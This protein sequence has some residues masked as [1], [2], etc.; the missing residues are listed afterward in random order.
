MNKS[1]KKEAGQL[2]AAARFGNIG[3]AARG[4]SALIRA[5]KT[6]KSRNELIMAASYVP[7]VIKHA[8]FVI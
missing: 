8:D 6:I 3:Y 5:A 1:E 2:D 4:F 7:A